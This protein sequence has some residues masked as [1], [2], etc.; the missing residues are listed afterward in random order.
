MPIPFARTEPVATA[1]LSASRAV[2]LANTQ[3]KY[4]S[5]H[6]AEAQPSGALL[7]RR[8]VRHQAWC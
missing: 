8:S 4:L 3:L 1:E 6:P 5:G 7:S 2:P